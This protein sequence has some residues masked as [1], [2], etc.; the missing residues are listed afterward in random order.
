[1]LFCRVHELAVFDYVSRSNKC[2]RCCFRVVLTK[3]RIFS[4]SAGV[5][6]IDYASRGNRTLACTLTG[7]REVLCTYVMGSTLS[8]NATQ[9]NT[10]NDIKTD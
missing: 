7:K 4:T 5:D 3:K 2:L 9:S 1:M 6:A 8:V 10:E